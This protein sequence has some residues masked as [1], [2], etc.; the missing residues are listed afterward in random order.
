MMIRVFTQQRRTG[1]K[2]A[3]AASY[4]EAEARSQTGDR[5]A[6]PMQELRPEEVHHRF[7]PDSH[8][9]HEDQSPSQDPVAR[10]D[11]AA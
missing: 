4:Q 9:C 1:L 8:H 7:Y 5:R 10:L 3:D 6:S 2:L 11:E